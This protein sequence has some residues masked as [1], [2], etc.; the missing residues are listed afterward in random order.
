M[1]YDNQNI[2]GYDIYYCS[3]TTYVSSFYSASETTTR[4]KTISCLCLLVHISG[5]DRVAVYQRIAILFLVYVTSA[6]HKKNDITINL[7]SILK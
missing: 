5:I 6:F 3:I 7:V 2:V 1:L 4:G